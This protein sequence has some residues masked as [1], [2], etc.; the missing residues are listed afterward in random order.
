MAH[1]LHRAELQL[2]PHPVDVVL[3]VEEQRHLG[4]GE[5]KLQPAL[6]VG[7]GDLAVEEGGTGA[8]GQQQGSLAAQQAEAG[9]QA[10]HLPRAPVA[11]G[12]QVDVHAGGNH[13]GAVGGLDVAVVRV[14]GVGALEMA[15]VAQAEGAAR[16][17]GELAA[18]QPPAQ[19]LT[20][21]DQ[22]L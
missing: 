16:Q 13:L 7:A 22:Q 20:R 12:P 3:V 1:V 9:K 8:E 14:C 11:D 19:A 17:Q 21:L 10:V 2:L 5:R 6:G 18:G 4:R 15:A